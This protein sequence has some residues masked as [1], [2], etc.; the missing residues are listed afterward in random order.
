[1]PLLTVSNQG[2]GTACSPA[3]AEPLQAV[4]LAFRRDRCSPAVP[5]RQVC[6]HPAPALFLEI[7][8]GNGRARPTDCQSPRIALQSTALRLQDRL[9]A[10]PPLQQTGLAL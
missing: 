4:N 8:Q 6:N 10:S 5:Q 3:Q 1:M 7:L 9:L 2:G